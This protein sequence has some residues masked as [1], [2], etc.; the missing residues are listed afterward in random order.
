MVAR[1]RLKRPPKR[2]AH[3]S[4]HRARVSLAEA[5]GV[6]SITPKVDLDVEHMRDEMNRE[7]E[8]REEDEDAEGESEDGGDLEGGDL[9]GGEEVTVGSQDIAGPLK[10]V[11][12]ADRTEDRPMKVRGD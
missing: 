2:S 10:D 4:P 11:V 1:R 12:T 6:E 7:D 9:E 5:A 8:R 3:L